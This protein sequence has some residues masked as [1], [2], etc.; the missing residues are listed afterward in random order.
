MM[1]VVVADTLQYKHII[2]LGHL[3]RVFELLDRLHKVGCE[4]DT[5]GNRQLHFDG[6]CKLVLLHI[7]NPLLES[8]PDLQ[9]AVGL[10]QVAK[11]LGVKRFSAGSFSESVRVFDPGQLLPI[12]EELT[13]QLPSFPQ[14]KRLSDLDHLLT[15]VDGTVLPAIAR[16]ARLVGGTC[17]DGLPATRYNTA[18]NGRAMH[19][20]RL[21][22]QFDLKTF[23][24]PSHRPHRGAQRRGKP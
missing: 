19:G 9:R 23:A 4:R 21:H 15:L 10:P 20:W 13:G 16:L 11:A 2:C 1:F 8:V 5:A 6:Y 17:A 18:R 14:D 7:W 24:P 22:T 12:I 3:K